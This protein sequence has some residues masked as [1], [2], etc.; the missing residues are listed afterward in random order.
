VVV[1]AKDDAGA[2]ALFRAALAQP[3]SYRRIE[4][5]DPAEGPLPGEGAEYPDLGRAAAFACSAGR[6]STPAFEP[7]EMAPLLGA[8]GR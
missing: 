3:L 7:A 2:G 1:G 4:W 5:L 6:C 8:L